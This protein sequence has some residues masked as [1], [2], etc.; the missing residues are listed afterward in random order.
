MTRK[1]INLLEQ[2]STLRLIY[3]FNYFTSLNETWEEDSK[4]TIHNREISKQLVV[5]MIILCLGTD[6]IQSII[7]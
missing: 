5:M 3:A 4:V 6:F 2:D 1:K 7:K